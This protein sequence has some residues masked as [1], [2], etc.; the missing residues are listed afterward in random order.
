MNNKGSLHL[1]TALV[2]TVALCGALGY[3]SSEAAY[4]AGQ[5]V[6]GTPEE[7]A[8]ALIEACKVNDRA[9]LMELFGDSARDMVITSDEALE[10]A[11]RRE[12]YD[13]ALEAQKL[14]K[15]QDGKIVVIVGVKEWPFPIPLIKDGQGW[16]FDTA[17]GRVEIL[18]RRV[19]MDELKAISACRAYVK[20]Q[21]QYADKDRNGDDVLEYA[22]KIGSSP[23]KKDGLYWPDEKDAE[24][25]PLGPLVAEAGDY[26]KA[27]KQGDPY[28][29]YYFR[30]LNGQGDKAAGGAYDY[31]INGHMLAG[32]ALLAYPAAYR[33]SG[34]MTFMVNSNGRVYQKDL[35]ADTA[36]TAGAMEKYN[37]DSTW[38]LVEEE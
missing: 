17:S 12:F 9:A 7:A 19:G 32:F 8:K 14:E 23:G 28:Y 33:S 25:S 20:A 26:G 38:K 37:P 6:F 2:I 24:L 13:W 27:R 30:I 22:Q 34:V 21:K 4:A 18:N 29:G 36:G 15:K 10:K 11:W 1:L 16:C 31:L 3:L 35:G 5:K